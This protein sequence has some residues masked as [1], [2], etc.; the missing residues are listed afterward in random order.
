MALSPYPHLFDELDGA[1]TRS[2]QLYTQR[3]SGHATPKNYRFTIEEMFLWMVAEFG[4]IDIGDIWHLHEQ[5]TPSTTW[6]INHNLNRPIIARVKDA[7][8]N[9][10][11]GEVADVSVDQ[12]TITFTIAISGEAI[13]H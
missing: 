6:T 7:S 1:F 2:T 12:A 4:L 10:V 13:I 3:V 5:T 9:N 8:G 11:V